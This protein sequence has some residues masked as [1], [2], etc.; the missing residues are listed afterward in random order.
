MAVYQLRI[1]CR[2][3]PSASSGWTAIGVLAGTRKAAEPSSSTGTVPRIRIASH[4]PAAA[5]LVRPGHAGIAEVV[6]RRSAAA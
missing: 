5:D 1:S 6:G 4:G 3:L 2:A